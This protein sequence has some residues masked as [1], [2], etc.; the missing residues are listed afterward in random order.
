MERFRVWKK[1]G[2]DATGLEGRKEGDS[3][4]AMSLLNVLGVKTRACA[5]EHDIRCHQ[6]SNVTKDPFPGVLNEITEYHCRKVPNSIQYIRVLLH[7]G[8]RSRQKHGSYYLLLILC[9]Q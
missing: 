9:T 1:E 3:W 5:E 6:T 8:Q 7:L 4:V 2:G